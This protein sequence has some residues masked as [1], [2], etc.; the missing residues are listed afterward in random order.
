MEAKTLSLLEH[1]HIAEMQSE[2][3]RKL[4]EASRKEAGAKGDQLSRTVL[5]TVVS[6]G[7]EIAKTKLADYVADKGSFPAFQD[8]VQ[9]YIQHCTELIHAIQ[10]KRNFPGLASLSLSRQQEIHEKVMEHF[11]ELKQ[12]LKHIERIERDHKLLDVRSTVWVLRSMCVVV[13][14]ILAAAWIADLRAGVLSSFIYTMNLYIDA[15][16]TWLVNLIL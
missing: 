5:H 8:R 14:S 11:E 9:R 10:T 7:Y 16:S 3:N 12:N 6:E 15:A 4:Q 13:S 2:L 1:T